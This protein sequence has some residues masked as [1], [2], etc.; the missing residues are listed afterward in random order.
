MK[1]LYAL[2]ARVESESVPQTQISQELKAAILADAEAVNVTLAEAADSV[3]GLNVALAERD[4]TIERQRLE[5]VRLT[6][7]V[8][9]DAG[10]VADT[11]GDLP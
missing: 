6:A 10:E 3:A 2:L 7:A 4:Q 11:R 5:I 1:H 8:V 9:S